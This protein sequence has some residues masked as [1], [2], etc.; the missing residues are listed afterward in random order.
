MQ[1]AN[2]PIFELQCIDYFF[3][4]AKYVLHFI[5]NPA[6]NMDSK[7]FAEVVESNRVCF[8]HFFAAFQAF[9][10]KLHKL[11][12]A[13]RME[14][15]LTLLADVK[16]HIEKIKRDI[17]QPKMLHAEQLPSDPDE[18]IVRMETL[19]AQG[20]A[21]IQAINRG[22]QDIAHATTLMQRMRENKYHMEA[23]DESLFTTMPKESSVR[24]EK[25]PRN[26]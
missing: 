6:T 7:A 15:K 12:Q 24:A 18:C 9:G 21:Q 3:T 13:S 14:L 22:F 19:I 26:G 11:S 10:K 25:K 4:R 8:P 20:H 2:K 17:H 16:E 1:L 23:F 5:D